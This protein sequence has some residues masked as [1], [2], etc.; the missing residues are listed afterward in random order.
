[1]TNPGLEAVF[2]VLSSEPESTIFVPHPGRVVC[3]GI[4][5]PHRWDERPDPEVSQ[6]IAQRCREVEPA[7]R[8]AEIIDT[9]TGLR[10]ARSSVRVEAERL[11][12]GRCVHNYGHDGNGVS[13]SWGCAREAAALAVED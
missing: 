1:M 2:I 11:G 4:R 8:D 9:V 5:V 7:L 12:S 6:R 13:L 10:P 3:G